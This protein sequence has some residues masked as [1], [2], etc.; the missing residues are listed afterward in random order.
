MTNNILRFEAGTLVLEMSDVSLFPF[1]LAGVFKHDPRTGNF[2]ARASDYSKVILAFKEKSL[3]LDDQARDYE[4]FTQLPLREKI[5]PHPHQEHAL[6]QWLAAS[7]RGVVSL[8][9]G[10]GKTILALLAIARLKR[11]AIVL[12]P[13]ID[14]LAQ[15]AGVLER[16]FSVPIGIL[17][18]G[19][20]R[21]EPITVST[22]DSAVLN[23]EFIGNKF[24]LLIADE[25]H[26]LPG[27]EF[28]LGAA[29]CIA[30]FRLGLS[31][32]LELDPERSER[33]RS[34]MGETVCSVGIDELEGSILSLYQVKRFF[35]QL[36]RE[37][38]ILYRRQRAIYTAFRQKH[39]I[40]FARSS[41]WRD[42]LIACSRFEG[43]REAFAAFLEQRK[44]AR[45]GKAKLAVLKNIL[46][47]HPGERIIIFTAD[48]DSAY[49]I[50]RYFTFPVLTHHTKAA[51]RKS[52]LESFRNGEFPVLVTSK[53]LNEGVDVPSAAVGVVFSGSGSVREHVQRLGR[54]LRPAPGKERAMLYELVS[55]GTSEEYT[56]SRRREHLAYRKHR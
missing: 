3:Q 46:L 9:T 13:T 37:E 32:T 24:A 48:N 34:L 26:H 10:A 18:G 49:E 42:F 19:E 20:H 43:G 40:S 28:Q 50:G 1:E 16:F 51:E 22:Y 39:G 45:A 7:G 15:W 30:P 36:S 35:V 47:N 21:I 38:E 52:F 55:A 4:K 33:L 41:G 29:M 53:V 23:M 11:P 14:L 25:C 6:E 54:I 2:R 44:T 17:G 56:S 31:A 5:V 12:V 27:A 8:P